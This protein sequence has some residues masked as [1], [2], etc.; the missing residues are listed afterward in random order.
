[1]LAGLN[2]EYLRGDPTDQPSGFPGRR[3]ALIAH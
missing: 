3:A 2:I 1:L